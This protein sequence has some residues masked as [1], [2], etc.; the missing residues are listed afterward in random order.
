MKHQLNNMMQ[1]YI[2]PNY[3]YISY[4]T[5]VQRYNYYCA[6]LYSVSLLHFYITT[7]LH[8]K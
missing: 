7:I 6:Y 5:K 3:Q 1:K 4:V 8:G 2:I